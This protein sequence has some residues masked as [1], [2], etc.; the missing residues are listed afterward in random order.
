MAVG[1]LWRSSNPLTPW[2]VKDRLGVHD[3]RGEEKGLINKDTVI[4]EP[5][6]GNTGIASP[7]VCALEDTGS[8]SSC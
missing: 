8:S 2:T 7:F 4:I 5:T 3:R 1:R 6:S